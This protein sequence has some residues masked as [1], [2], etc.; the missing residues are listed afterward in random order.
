MVREVAKRHCFF[1]NI[2]KSGG[3][4]TPPPL[5]TFRN[6]NVNFGQK[7]WPPKFHIKFRNT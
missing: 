3:H 7:Q 6:N 4:P 5:S 1:R 2:S